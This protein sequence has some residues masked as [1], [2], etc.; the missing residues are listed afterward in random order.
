MHN[1]FH[2]VSAFNNG[3]VRDLRLDEEA[4]LIKEYFIIAGS[5]FVNIDE[6]SANAPVT[7]GAAKLVP[8]IRVYR[9]S[10]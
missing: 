9:P 3:G 1:N 6:R 5:Y 2:A 7:N 8:L 10:G 4:L